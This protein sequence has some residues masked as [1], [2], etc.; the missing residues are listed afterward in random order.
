M[1]HAACSSCSAQFAWARRR[2]P[3]T[4]ATT[5][6][7]ANLLAVVHALAARI[8]IGIARLHGAGM[9]HGDLTTSNMMLRGALAALPPTNAMPSPSASTATSAGQPSATLAAEEDEHGAYAKL[10]SIVPR[11]MTAAE[12]LDLGGR[13]PLPVVSSRLL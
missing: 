8:G 4:R 2:L 11:S 7:S 1:G 9:V 13:C 5:L 3:S 6:R 10:A 12:A